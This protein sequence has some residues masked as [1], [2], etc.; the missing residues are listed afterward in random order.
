MT[1]LRLLLLLCLRELLSNT[2]QRYALDPSRTQL[3][4]HMP[5]QPPPDPAHRPDSWMSNAIS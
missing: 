1:V 2:Q 3:R 4:T 5:E